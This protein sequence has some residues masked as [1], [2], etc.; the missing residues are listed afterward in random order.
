MWQVEDALTLNKKKDDVN[1]EWNRIS[2]EANLTPEDENKVD[3]FKVMLDYAKTLNEEEDTFK[4]EI[5]ALSTVEA[6]ESYTYSFSPIPAMEPHTEGSTV[7]YGFIFA[8]RG[9]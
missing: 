1:A 3:E 2:T 8:L 7:G 9:Y 5:E 6:V 4:A